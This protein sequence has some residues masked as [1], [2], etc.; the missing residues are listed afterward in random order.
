MRI[1][2]RQIEVYSKKKYS[3][4]NIT[5]YIRHP[6][7][8][9]VGI[10]LR[11]AYIWPDKLYLRMLYYFTMGKRLRLDNP[12]TFTQKINWL[13]VNDQHQEYSQLVDKYKVK[14]YV[15]EKLS[16]DENIIKTIGVWNN[17]EEINFSI[18]P[19][20]FVL[21]TT[22]GGGSSSVV[23]C[24]DKSKFNIEETKQK[25]RLC[26]GKKSFIWSRE[27]PYYNITPRII[28]E[29]YIET[30]DDELSDY[31]F[32]C[33]NGEPKFLFVGTERQKE[34]QDVKFDFFDT[35]FNHLPIKNGHENAMQPPSKPKNFEEMLEIAR[36]L[37]KNIPHVRVDLYNVEGKIYFGELTFFHFGG[38]VRFEPEKWDQI[39][40][41][42]LK[43]PIPDK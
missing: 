42:Y 29:E 19:D 14:D 1:T 18:L 37:S 34:G 3:M 24:K 4:R 6:K 7:D 5:E 8:L 26:S 32:F 12:K 9:I 23:I 27:Y 21:K 10:M 33:F 31:K 40:G 30:R 16:T 22:N 43:L 25:L 2:S 11:T 17:F 41:E 39:F 36:K 15:K 35:K 38:F 28:A 20:K 13:K